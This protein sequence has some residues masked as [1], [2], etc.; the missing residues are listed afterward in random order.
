M[1]DV[2][3]CPRGVMLLPTR[4][5]QRA[6]YFARA[7]KGCSHSFFFSSAGVCK[8]KWTERASRGLSSAKM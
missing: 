6:K 5:V 1:E 4:T 3:Q 2:I 7:K 8:K